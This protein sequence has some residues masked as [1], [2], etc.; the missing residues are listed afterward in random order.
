MVEAG[1]VRLHYGVGLAF[2]LSIC[3]V[4]RAQRASKKNFFLNRYQF[5]TSNPILRL[6]AYL[7]LN[8]QARLLFSR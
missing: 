1:G 7:H 3:G 8:D 6:R 4:N 2:E 5:P